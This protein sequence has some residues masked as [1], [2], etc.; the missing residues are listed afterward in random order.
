MTL[1]YDQV[2]GLSAPF[3]RKSAPR[4]PARAGEV[5]APSR[6]AGA[7]T[8]D[9]LR[10]EEVLSAGWPEPLLAWAVAPMRPADEAKL[11]AALT[12]MCQEDRSLRAAHDPET[13]ELVVAGQGELQL[14]IA[15][16]RLASEHE[17]SVTPRRPDPALSR[18]DHAGRACSRASQEA[19]G[20]SWRVRRCPP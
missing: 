20:G 8:G 13:G 10:S 2:G 17:L 12:R 11:S 15:L 1:G 19:V 18:D 16:S 3:G 9:L 6:M 4:G 5:V 14:G 7:A